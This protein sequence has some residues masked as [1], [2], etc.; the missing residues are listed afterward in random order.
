MHLHQNVLLML[1]RGDGQVIP[2][3]LHTLRVNMPD[4]FS[5]K[6][7][8][9]AGAFLVYTAMLLLSHYVSA[10]IYLTSKLFLLNNIIKKLRMI[11]LLVH[12]RSYS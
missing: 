1:Q 4:Q 5:F 11:V 7:P 6:W 3:V 8:T 2:R 9:D 10:F 12:F